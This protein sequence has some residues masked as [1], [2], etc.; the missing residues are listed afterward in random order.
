VERC[1]EQLFDVMR[2]PR[3]EAL[4][5][6]AAA[7][8]FDLGARSEALDASKVAAKTAKLPAVAWASVIR[9]GASGVEHGPLVKEPRFR[10]IELG[11]VE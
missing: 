2:N 1:K 8:L 5:G 7:A 3:R 6:L 9:A 4:R 10:W 11:W